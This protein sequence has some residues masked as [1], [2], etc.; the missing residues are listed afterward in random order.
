MR[1]VPV[2]EHAL[3][4]R[5]RGQ[6]HAVLQPELVDLVHLLPLDRAADG[7]VLEAALEREHDRLGQ[8]GVDHARRQADVLHLRI[9]GQADLAAL[10]DQ[11]VGTLG[12]VLG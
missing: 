5:D 1:D 9:A 3:H 4:A 12:H 11:H 2:A 6:L 7:V 10:D 8:A